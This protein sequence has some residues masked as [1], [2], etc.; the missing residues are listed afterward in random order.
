[1]TVNDLV[2]RKKKIKSYAGFTT[3]AAKYTIEPLTRDAYNYSREKLDRETTDRTGE[4][5]QSLT[6][7][8]WGLTGAVKANAPHAHLIEYGT[9][10]RST[11]SGA[12]RGLVRPVGFMRYGI[13]KAKRELR[14]VWKDGLRKA[15][16]EQS[17]GA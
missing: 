6:W 13:R 4:L 5:K 11:S 10:T 16:R 15:E 1:V 9:S 14:K 2:K 7:D 17:T 8:V 12:N 3:G